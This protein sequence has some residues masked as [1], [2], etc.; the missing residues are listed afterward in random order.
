M[1]KIAN[2]LDNLYMQNSRHDMNTTLSTLICD[3]LISPA[4]APERMV[5]EHA[6]LIAALHANVGTE[7][8]ANLLET[9]VDRF[10]QMTE[11]G[12]EQYDVEDKTLDNVVFT[13]CH[14]YTFKVSA[15]FFH[16]QI[17]NRIYPNFIL[18]IDLSPSFNL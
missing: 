5:M 13:L 16:N 14:M 6:M 17:R 15:S 2:E 10:H 12:I 11:N 3:A 18:F 9:L 7:V 1:H 8:G 4:I